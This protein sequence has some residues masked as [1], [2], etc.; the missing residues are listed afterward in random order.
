MTAEPSFTSHA[1]AGWREPFQGT[2]SCGIVLKGV[3]VE[4]VLYTTR[5]DAHAAVWKWKHFVST[6]TVSTYNCRE[7]PIRLV[8]NDFSF[9]PYWLD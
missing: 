5:A 7:D 9:L 2:V 8:G 1:F 6:P 3:R 4:S